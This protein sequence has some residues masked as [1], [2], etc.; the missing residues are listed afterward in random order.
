MRRV[1]VTGIG[2]ITPLGLGVDVS[3]NNLVSAKSGIKIIPETLFD[4][5]GLNCKIAAYI[6]TKQED[7]EL[8]FDPADYMTQKVA[9]TMDKFIHL[10][11][12]AAKEAVEDAGCVTGDF[13][14][15][16]RTGTLVGSG[17]GGFISIEN[18]TKALIEKGAR[19]IS[20]FF[21]PGSLVNLIAGN[22]SMQYGFKGPNLSVVTA[23]ATGAHAIGEAARVIICDDADVMICGG[24][25]ATLCRLGMAGFAAIRALS[26]KYNAIP[27]QASRPWDKGRDGFVM[28]EGAGILVL[29]ELEHAR[30]RG[31]KIYAELVGYGATS[32]AFHVTAPEPNGDGGFRAIEMAIK[33][34]KISPEDIDYINAHGTSTVLG[35]AI[36]LNI[37]KRI[38]EGYNISGVAMSSTKSSIGHL[39]GAAGSVEAIFCLLAM[40]NNVA[41]PTL[42]L[43]EL[44]EECNIN[45]VPHHAIQKKIDVTLSN[46]FGFGGTNAALIFKKI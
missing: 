28:G 24:T 25:E 27:G 3:W 43:H 39:L 7:S 44:D 41:P 38:F 35:D 8:G 11:M 18:N 45:L 9:R 2:L 13:S 4:T 19:S 46:S 29:E 42:N 23:C 16:L 6:P 10:A 31:A 30:R 14:Q 21:V 36:E 26:T 37:V 32:D 40:N 17:V 34:A 1:V 15:L 22:I 5:N 12:A 33:K 20:P